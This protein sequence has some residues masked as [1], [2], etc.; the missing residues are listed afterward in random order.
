MAFLFLWNMSFKLLCFFF[1]LFTVPCSFAAAQDLTPLQALPARLELGFELRINRFDTDAGRYRSGI[2]PAISIGLGWTP[3][4]WISVHGCID[5]G[6][7]VTVESPMTYQKNKQILET[8]HLGSLGLRAALDMHWP[9][10][11][12]IFTIDISARSY[13]APSRAGMFVIDTGIALG[14]EPFHANNPEAMLQSLRFSA[15]VRFPLVDDFDTIFGH[16]RT[17]PVVVFGIVLA[18]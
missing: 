1:F 9:S 11:L 4:D 6:M 5:I 15:G 3:L 7:A 18:Y 17:I 2:E 12:A 8:W 16:K 14:S 13:F 10:K